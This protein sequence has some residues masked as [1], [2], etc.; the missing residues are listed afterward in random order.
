MSAFRQDSE[1]VWDKQRCQVVESFTNQ[2]GQ[3]ALIWETVSTRETA[4][5]FIDCSNM[6]K[7][8]LQSKQPSVKN[9]GLLWLT[10]QTTWQ[11]RDTRPS[12]GNAEPWWEECGTLD[13]SSPSETE[14]GLKKRGR[15]N[16][17]TWG[18][19]WILGVSPAETTLKVH[20]KPALENQQA[21]KIHRDH[22]G[23]TL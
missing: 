7:G 1:W 15:T 14:K 17:Q 3:M 9:N 21:A 13:S 2:T 10:E 19:G 5:L 16:K 23:F 4:S 6:Q 18:H 22:A 11:G 20:S 8:Q 12:L